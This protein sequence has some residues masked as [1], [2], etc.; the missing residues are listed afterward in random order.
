MFKLPFGMYWHCIF[1][2]PPTCS[3]IGY[4]HSLGLIGSPV[5]YITRVHAWNN[6]QTHNIYSRYIQLRLAM[7][8][9]KLLLTTAMCECTNKFVPATTSKIIDMYYPFFMYTDIFYI[10]L[11]LHCVNRV[12]VFCRLMV[13]FATDRDVYNLLYLSCVCT[14][15]NVYQ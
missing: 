4:G 5:P 3:H 14:K 7:A 12:A 11:Y 8:I 2:G 1:I 15:Q 13:I 6:S 10:L 9:L